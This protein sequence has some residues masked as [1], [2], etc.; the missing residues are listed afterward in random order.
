MIKATQINILRKCEFEHAD[1]MEHYPDIRSCVLAGYL[2]TWE[3]EKKYADVSNFGN[4]CF[5]WELKD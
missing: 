2:M 3:M 1:F 4:Q 5:D